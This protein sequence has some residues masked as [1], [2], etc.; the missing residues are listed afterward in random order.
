MSTVP[1]NHFFLQYVDGED[2]WIRT[3]VIAVFSKGKLFQVR[4]LFS[5]RQ[6][7]PIASDTPKWWALL[8][9]GRIFNKEHK[10][11]S[12]KTFKHIYA[13]GES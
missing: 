7:Q 9:E 11:F 4:P 10:L 12:F 13:N 8:E 1:N 6:P 3:D 5:V 2:G